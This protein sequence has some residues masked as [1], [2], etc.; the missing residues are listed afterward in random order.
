MKSESS[1]SQNSI[2]PTFRQ[3]QERTSI[4][5]KGSS[6]LLVVF[7]VSFLSSLYFL[8]KYYHTKCREFIISSLIVSSVFT[9][10]V[11]FLIGKYLTRQSKT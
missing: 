8:P 10:I 1:K 4:I 9:C 6:I 7:I 3:C 2:N 5:E 11:G